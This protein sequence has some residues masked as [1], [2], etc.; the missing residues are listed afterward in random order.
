MTGRNNSYSSS[1]VPSSAPLYHAPSRSSTIS[2]SSTKAPFAESYDM[3]AYEYSSRSASDPL[4]RT[5]AGMGR[6]SASYNGPSSSS[7]PSSLSSGTYNMSDAAAASGVYRTTSRSTYAS[8]ASYSSSYPPSYTSSLASTASLPSVSSP[9]PRHSS[10]HSYATSTAGSTAGN[11]TKK[12]NVNVYT[13]CGRHSN[14]W[15]FSGWPS[16]F[17]R[18][19]GN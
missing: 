12:T 1:R 5:S 2:S 11:S 3:P 14:E 17:R 19:D 6:A 9:P 4:Y 13:T 16:P 8:S 10:A 7:L 18:R 15:L